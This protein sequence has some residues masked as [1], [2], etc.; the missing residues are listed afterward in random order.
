[1]VLHDTSVSPM[2]GP[3]RDWSTALSTMRMTL[4]REMVRKGV[5]PKSSTLPMRGTDSRSG[6]S[7]MGMSL[8]RSMASTKTQE[9]AWDSTVAQ[10]A[11]AT[12]QPKAKIKTGSSAMFI[13]APT[14]TVAMPRPEYPWQ[15]RKLFIPVAIMAKKEPAV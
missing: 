7:R 10:A 12:P 8:R 4:S 1:M 2:P 6:S 15:M 3:P 13:T 5:R 9:A 11:P 14:A